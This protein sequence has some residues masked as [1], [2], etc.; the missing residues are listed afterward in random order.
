M[1]DLKTV[2][3]LVVTQ[4]DYRI[5][6]LLQSKYPNINVTSE[7]SDIPAAFP[8]ICLYEENSQET[9]NDIYNQT[10]NAVNSYVHVVVTT[11]TSRADVK[12]IKGCVLDIMKYLRY[13]ERSSDYVKSN[14]L[15][16]FNMHF[17]RTLCP[18]DTF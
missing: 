8:N 17:K 11:N 7:I 2:E 13:T 14:N 5:K 9:G 12:Y 1:I 4:V 3:S 15:H 18:G 10:V 6:K 16:I